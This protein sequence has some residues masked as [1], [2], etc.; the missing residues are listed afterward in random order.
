[1]DAP[2]VFNA[3]EGN[4]NVTSGTDVS[5][6]DNSFGKSPSTGALIADKEDP[7]HAQR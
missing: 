2:R 4:Q 5:R 1:M 6:V 7:G 3:A